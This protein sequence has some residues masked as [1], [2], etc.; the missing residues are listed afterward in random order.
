MSFMLYSRLL[1]H[2]ALAEWVVIIF[3]CGVCLYV[4]PEKQKHAGA[5]TQKYGTTRQGR[6]LVFFKTT[7]TLC[8]LK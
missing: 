4:C 2:Q 7:S 6:L 5:I 1:T 8:S 3:T